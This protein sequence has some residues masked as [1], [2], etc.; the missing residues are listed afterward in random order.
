[1]TAY[2]HGELD[3]ETYL[4]VE[5]TLIPLLNQLRFTDESL[6]KTIAVSFILQKE[7]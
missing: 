2:L 7:Q 5:A 4:E 1:M 3:V 6:N